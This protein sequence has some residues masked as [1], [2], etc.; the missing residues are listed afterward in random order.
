MLAAV[1]ISLI[2]IAQSIDREVSGSM[3]RDV[4]FQIVHERTSCRDHRLQHIMITI[5]IYSFLHFSI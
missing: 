5:F 1:S 2:I 3:I 4:D